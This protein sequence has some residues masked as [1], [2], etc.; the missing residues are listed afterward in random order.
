MVGSVCCSSC[1]CCCCCVHT[2][3]GIV[4]S[5]QG[6][7]KA[8]KAQS[9][10]PEATAGAERM[11]TAYWAI[12]GGLAWLIVVGGLLTGQLIAG[13]IAVAFV[14]PLLQ[15][16]VSLVCLPVARSQPLARRAGAMAAL[17]RMTLGGLLGLAIGIAF[18]GL[19][20]VVLV[21]LG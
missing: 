1:C 6:S 8:I 15:L 19:T 21:G 2:V 20:V 9:G 4:G 16:I 10:N 11:V 18:G 17:K 5:V 13:L 7:V 14:G 3:A 12:A